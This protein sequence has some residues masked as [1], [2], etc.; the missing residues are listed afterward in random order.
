MR[1]HLLA[2]PICSVNL[3]SEIILFKLYKYLIINSS[4]ILY[5]TNHTKIHKQW[6]VIKATSN[7]NSILCQMCHNAKKKIGSNIN[8]ERQKNL[9]LWWQCT[10]FSFELFNDLI[11]IIYLPC[12]FTS[13]CLILLVVVQDTLYISRGCSSDLIYYI[14]CSDM[15][16][17][18][19]P[20]KFQSTYASRAGTHF[21]GVVGAY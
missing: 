5:S 17:G 11:L 15:S 9:E 1:L 21:S 20:S 4:F 14:L 13:G 16:K 7:C 18:N 12:E 19:R 2:I 8:A 6:E 3:L 10:Q